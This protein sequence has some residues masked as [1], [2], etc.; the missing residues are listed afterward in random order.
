MS[1]PELYRIS[2]VPGDACPPVISTLPVLKSG[3][4]K[5]KSRGTFTEPLLTKAPLEPRIFQVDGE[6]PKDKLMR[7]TCLSTAAQR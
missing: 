3:Q 4:V 5:L 7:S 1:P 6:T 2:Q